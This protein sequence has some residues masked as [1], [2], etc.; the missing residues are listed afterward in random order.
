MG[1]R[2]SKKRVIKMKAQ[3]VSKIFDCPFCNHS[4]TVECKLDKRKNIGTI[5][6]RIC[7]VSFQTIIHHLSE[8]VDV[9]SDWIDECQK[10]NE[11]QN[12]AANPND[13]VDNDSE[14]EQ[15][16][17]H[18]DNTHRYDDDDDDDA[19]QHNNHNHGNFR[20]EIVSSGDEEPSGHDT[21]QRRLL[22]RNV[23]DDEEEEEFFGNPGV[24]NGQM[25]SN[26]HNINNTNDYSQQNQYVQ[27]QQYQQQYVQQDSDDGHDY[28]TQAQVSQTY[29]QQAAAH[30]AQQQQQQQQQNQ[31]IPTMS[32]EW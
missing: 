17:P 6:C 20:N 11:A 24:N 16:D 21:Q 19:T 31:T 13:D 12:E 8:P 5:N 30:Y 22:Q 27:P 10:V 28:Q 18:N 26:A 9:Y 3:S 4:K 25:V 1:R 14:A 7:T 23:D 29:A 15:I 32:Q 2:K